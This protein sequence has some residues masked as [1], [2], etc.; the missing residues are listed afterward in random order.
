MKNLIL[1]VHVPTPVKEGS[2]PRT[3][4]YNE[5]LYLQSIE[6]VRQYSKRLGVDYKLI[7]ESRFP[8]PAFD[9]FQLFHQDN[10]QYD[11]VLYVDCDMMLHESTP[12]LFEWTKDRPEWFFATPDTIAGDDD[13]FNSGFFVIKRPLIEEL[14]PLIDD[15]VERHVDSPWKDQDA[16]N[17]IL[18]KEKYWCKLSRDWNGVMALER[19]LF[20]LHYAGMRK[21]DFKL[22]KHHR[23]IRRKIYRIDVMTDEEILSKYLYKKRI[24]NHLF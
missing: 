15:A 23:I 2:F 22:E 8:H 20:S 1:Q 21:H 9:R 13:Y 24:I 12:N 16:F 19:P 5:D 4:T 7:E 3:F 17:E 14:R 6:S 10:S 18:P 11:Q